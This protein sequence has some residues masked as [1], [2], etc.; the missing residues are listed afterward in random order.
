MQKNIAKVALVGIVL[1]LTACQ[2]NNVGQMFSPY[3]TQVSLTQ[4]VQ[5]ALMQTNDPV[6]ARVHVETMQNDVVLSGYVKKIRQSDTAQ[7]IAEKV[8]GV[9]T[10]TNHL[11][12]RQ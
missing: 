12:V 8:P 6:L 5:D 11:I 4:T 3:P 9:K 10:V 7:Q 1:L 2:S